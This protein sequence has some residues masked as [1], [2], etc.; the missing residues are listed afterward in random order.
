MS[1]EN[2]IKMAEKYN[3][4]AA[5]FGTEAI[6]EH[7]YGYGNVIKFKNGSEII[8]LCYKGEPT[9]GQKS[10]QVLYDDPPFI[11]DDTM[12]FFEDF[13]SESKSKVEHR[14]PFT[15]RSLL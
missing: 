15:C 11:D 6:Q 10:Y 7:I 5:L 4:V 13:F 9:R 1:D 3:Y 2:L 12:K 14:K 8:P